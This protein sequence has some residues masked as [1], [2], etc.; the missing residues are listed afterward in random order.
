MSPRETNGEQRP[1]EPS[2]TSRARYRLVFF[3]VDSTLVSIEGIDILAGGDP[4]AGSSLQCQQ[5]K[6]AAG[7]TLLH[8]VRIEFSQIR[9]GILTGIEHL[10]YAGLFELLYD[11]ASKID[12]IMRRPDART[13]LG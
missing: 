7:P 8:P 10:F 6:H 5:C 13:K 2:D 9:R 4:D 1:E 11:I 3:D 12:F